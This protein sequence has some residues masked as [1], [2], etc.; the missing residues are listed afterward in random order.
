MQAID[1]TISIEDLLQQFPSAVRIL[2][3]YGL[4]CYACGEAVWG[5]LAEVAAEKR[6]TNDELEKLLG[7]LN[8]AKL[9]QVDV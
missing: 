9:E 1:R 8:K 6:L 7:Q 3:E 5:T 4:P 2:L